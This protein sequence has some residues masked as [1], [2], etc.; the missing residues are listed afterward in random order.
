MTDSMFD[1]VNEQDVYERMIKIR[2][3]LGDLAQDNSSDD[4]SYEDAFALGEMFKGDM[5]LFRFMDE[6]PG[7]FIVNGRAPEGA[8]RGPGGYYDG[9][10]REGWHMLLRQL[11]NGSETFWAGFES[12]KVRS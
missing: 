11:R 4:L 9:E 12:S 7:H 8:Y 5:T 2:D 10:G 3:R 1:H 6:K